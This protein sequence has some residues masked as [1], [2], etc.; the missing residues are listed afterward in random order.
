MGDI[1]KIYYATGGNN[2]G[3]R[4]FELHHP[5]FCHDSWWC[6]QIANNGWIDRRIIHKIIYKSFEKGNIKKWNILI[7]NYKN[8][9]T[10]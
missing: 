4:F 8:L 3:L 9:K 5:W 10:T 1:K 7:K 6:R 2:Y